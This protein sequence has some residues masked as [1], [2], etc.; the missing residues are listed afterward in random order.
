MILSK[1]CPHRSSFWM[2]WNV[3]AIVKENNLHICDPNFTMGIIDRKNNVAL[4]Y[5]QTYSM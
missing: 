1:N 2:L 3:V 4:K 5:I